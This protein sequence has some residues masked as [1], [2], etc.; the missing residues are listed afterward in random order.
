MPPAD[1]TVPP[2]PPPASGLRER[3]KRERRE[4]LVDEAQRLVR[5]RG[6]DAVTVED[7]CASVGVSPRTFFNYF[8]SKDDAV[9][10]LSPVD[11]DPE[12][13]AT[14]LAGGPSGDLLA[15]VEVLV[16][17]FLSGPFMTPE[18]M[19]ATLE[20]VHAEPRLLVRHLSW[21]EGHR[22]DLEALFAARRAAHP[23]EPTAELLG[24]VVMTLVRG[25]AHEW[26]RAGHVGSPVDHLPSVV[27]QLR[28]LATPPGH[29]P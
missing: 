25:A 4:A 22:A 7:V 1:P 29:S 24:F 3:K 17:H 11:V 23:F 10:G 28:A 16:A 13:T 12:I 6:L 15:D 8:A 18:R 5:E 2:S 20:L 19:A 26:E 9:L 27:Q 14:F 21:I